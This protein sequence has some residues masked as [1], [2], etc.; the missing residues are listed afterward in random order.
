MSRNEK[1]I[2]VV[3][4]VAFVTGIVTFT[5][6]GNVE[7]DGSSLG[8]SAGLGKDKFNA[9]LRGDLADI[10]RPTMDEGAWFTPIAQITASGADI[11][12]SNHP[13][14]RRPSHAGENRHKVITEGWGGWFYNP[15]SEEYF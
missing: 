2:L 9:S 6:K 12:H 8:A 7:A 1:I 4:V 13:L 15:P 10:W 3:L 5:A 11:L 14:F